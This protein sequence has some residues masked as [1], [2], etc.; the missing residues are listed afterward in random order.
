MNPFPQSSILDTSTMIAVNINGTTY[1]VW[2]EDRSEVFQHAGAM[3]QKAVWEPRC[4]WED[5]LDITQS[6][7]GGGEFIAGTTLFLEGWVYP[8][9][10][11]WTVQGVTTKGE[12]L[13]APAI[14]AQQVT[15]WT[16]TGGMLAYQRC[17]LTVQF[18][19][20]EY[21]ISTPSTGEQELDFC[22]NS[23]PLNNQD[24]AFSWADGTPFHPSQYPTYNFPTVQ[25]QQSL[26][27]RANLPTAGILVAADKVNS[28]PFFGAPAT[29]VLFKGCRTSRKIT[30]LGHNNWDLHF[31]FEYHPFGWN[32]RFRESTGQWE[33]Y[34]VKGT[35]NPRHV[36][37]DLNQL[38]A[39]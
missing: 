12:G 4:L 33:D 31:S 25:F 14:A 27:N 8:D 7:L 28:S 26:Y 34:V 39:L 5:R 38:L 9:N 37:Y 29:Q 3:S 30:P 6:L 36:L 10:P 11:A 13:R 2:D 20:P 23:I 18:G 21:D 15:S 17:K 24:I 22:N 32:K 1:N 16:P 19:I 35:G